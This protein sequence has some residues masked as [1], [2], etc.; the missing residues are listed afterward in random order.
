VQSLSSNRRGSVYAVVAFFLAIVFFAVLWFFMYSDDGFVT[1]TVNA[2]EAIHTTLNTTSHE[3]YDDSV[4]FM[5]GIREWILALVLIGLV[6]AGL[7]YTQRKRAEE[8]Y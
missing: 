1:K 6:I 4:N 8:Y 2:A 3:L 7:V 5:S